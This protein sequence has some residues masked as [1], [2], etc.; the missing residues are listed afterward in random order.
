[1]IVFNHE[2]FEYLKF[3]RLINHKNFYQCQ[4]PYLMYNTPFLYKSIKLFIIMEFLI[5]DKAYTCSLY[6]AIN[7]LLLRTYCVLLDWFLTRSTR[8]IHKTIP[9][10]T[11]YFFKL[12]GILS[13]FHPHKLNP[14]KLLR[15]SSSRCPS[16][17]QR[18]FWSWFAL[19]V[20]TWKNK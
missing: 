4:L 7:L 10:V 9:K 20:F 15:L 6:S 17:F 8:F 12:L 2:Q 14:S 19:L 18:K 11:R 1:M 3:I 5:H 13:D 16:L